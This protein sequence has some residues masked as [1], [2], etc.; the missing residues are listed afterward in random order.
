[1]TRKQLEILAAGNRAAARAA[2]ARMLDGIE[3]YE[4]I[5][6]DRLSARQAAERLGV[7]MRTIVRWRA[8]LRGASHG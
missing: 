3:D 2:R 7:T 6:G 5:G 8:Y 1:M 4:F